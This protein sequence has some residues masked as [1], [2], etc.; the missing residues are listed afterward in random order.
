ML[1][2]EDSR[3]GLTLKPRRRGARAEPALLMGARQPK[4]TKC[5]TTEH[6]ESA[7]AVVPMRTG[8]PSRGP[9]RGKGVP[10][11]GPRHGTMPYETRSSRAI[12]PGAAESEMAT[13]R[14]HLPELTLGSFDME[15]S[16]CYAPTMLTLALFVAFC[17]GPSAQEDAA[18]APAVEAETVVPYDVAIAA[19]SP[20]V[21]ALAHDST[22][23]ILNAEDG[24]VLKCA[25]APAPEGWSIDVS[26]DGRT[27][28]VL[29]RDGAVR[30]WRWRDEEEPR[31]V[32][33]VADKLAQRTEWPFGCEISFSPDGERLFVGYPIAERLLLSGEGEV[34]KH[35]ARISVPSI[36]RLDPSLRPINSSIF[37]VPYAWSPDGTRLA[38][39]TEGRPALHDARTG[40]HLDIELEPFEP[41]AQCCT[42]DADGRTLTVGHDGGVVVAWD[43]ETGKQRW[44]FEY[45]DPWFGKNGRELCS[46]GIGDVAYS[47]DGSLLAVTTT[48]GVYALL[49][50]PAT[51]EK[52]WMGADCGSRMGEPARITWARNSKSF[53]HAYVSNAMP[54]RH[55][56]TQHAA[57]RAPACAAVE[58]ALRCGSPV[59]VGWNGLAVGVTQRHVEA[60]HSTTAKVVWSFDG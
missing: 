8:N 12:S 9:G 23:R 3:S 22:I 26:P 35:L 29:S 21:A 41:S 53:F 33:R 14:T 57:A 30:L 17:R 32:A 50:D 36:T 54:L 51:G 19:T 31:E 37:G 4:E 49:L 28:A 55:V 20:V 11:H 42:F 56:L 2:T 16:T 43:L 58:R 1:S 44:T 27:V 60:L 10:R 46:F 38:V 34:I 39:V 45:E 40:A 13:R 18:F 24:T 59:D 25:K 48:S 15:L 5:G 47:P 6:E 52:F 7:Y